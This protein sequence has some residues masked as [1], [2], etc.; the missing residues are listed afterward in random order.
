MI[1]KHNTREIR[2]ALKTNYV[3][4]NT[5]RGPAHR[6][7]SVHSTTR[8]A[9]CGTNGDGVHILHPTKK[10]VKIFVQVDGHL[11]WH[12]VFKNDLVESFAELLPT[13]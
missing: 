7:I 1:L 2:A 3:Y 5:G 13:K 8:S 12:Q 4:W 10:I 9:V 6:V 11:G